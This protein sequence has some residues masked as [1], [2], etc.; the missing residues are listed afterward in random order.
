[1]STGFNFTVTND[2]PYGMTLE[3]PTDNSNCLDTDY[4]TPNPF[5]GSTFPIPSGSEFKSH[6]FRKDGHGC[7]GREGQFQ[8]RP[9]FAIGSKEVPGDYQ[10]FNFDAEG[11]IGLVGSPPNYGSQL[12]QP[13]GA[14]TDAT[15]TI[16]VFG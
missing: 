9:H 5:L 12:E 16:T 15:W 1:M 11:G 2:S 14:G 4:I 7:N 10:V 8:A 3:V 13:G 6:L